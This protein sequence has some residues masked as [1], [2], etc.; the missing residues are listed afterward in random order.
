MR[1]DRHLELF[2]ERPRDG[3]RKQQERGEVTIGDIDVEAVD[4]GGNQ[5]PGIAAGSR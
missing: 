2:T 4:A 3:R 5:P 1:F